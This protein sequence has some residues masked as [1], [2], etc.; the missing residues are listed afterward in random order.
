MNKGI[1]ILIAPL[2]WGLGHATRCI[3]IIRELITQGAEVYIAGTKLTNSIIAE[4]FPTLLYFDLNGYNVTYSKSKSLLPLK[5]VLQIPKILKAIN[6]EHAVLN[7]LVD[8]YHFD[9]II[10][11]N[12]YGFYHP[13]VHSVFITH[14][15]QIQIP[16]SKWVQQ[17]TNFINHRW[18]RKFNN[19]WIPDTVDN[20]FAGSLSICPKKIKHE[21]LGILSRLNP[22]TIK[23][24]SSSYKFDIVALLSGPEPQRSHLE[25]KL[26]QIFSES[27]S[28]KVLIVRGL[29][30]HGND[31]ECVNSSIDRVGHLPPVELIKYL[32][33]AGLII[34]RSGYSTIM[35]LAS[36]GESALL[37]PTP[38]QT[39]QEYLAGHLARKGYCSVIPQ[40]ELSL[41]KIL[42][43]K[44]E[45]K[46]IKGFK[47]DNNQLQNVILKEIQRV[48]K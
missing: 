28:I 25:A 45:L 6:T 2:D 31:F 17:F 23:D 5:M 39:E 30:K 42:Q 16:Q 29:P 24:V 10:S 13:K 4:E 3:P 1:K 8:Q 44:T 18:I 41:K 27:N 48:I 11:D 35:D 19:C 20:F 9:M 46:E 38:G 47:K 14:Q 34:C 7:S 21:Y 37:V 32:Q 40:E 36:I 43:G 22:V 33:L 12:R 15:L 26:L